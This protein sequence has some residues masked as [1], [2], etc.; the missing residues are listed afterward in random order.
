MKLELEQLHMKINQLDKQYILLQKLN[1]ILIHMV[2]I[3]KL[4]FYMKV[5]LQHK[6][7]K[8][9]QLIQIQ[10]KYKLNHKHQF[11]LHR[12]NRLNH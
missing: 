9:F 4:D 12:L 1:N 5:F 2:L 7:N 3:L 10:L 11:N 6:L 8:F